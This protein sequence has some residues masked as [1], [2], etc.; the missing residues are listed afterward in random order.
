MHPRA[1]VAGSKVKTAWTRSRS[2]AARSERAPLCYLLA[3]PLVG[4]VLNATLRP[5]RPVTRQR[6]T[7]RNRAN[8]A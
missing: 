7:H 6:L 3:V 2:E 8:V 1:Q 4:L 5:K